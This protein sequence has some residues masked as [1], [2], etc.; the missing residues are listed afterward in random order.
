MMLH[1]SMDKSS[2]KCKSA[3]ALICCL[4][5]QKN[6]NFIES[7]NLKIQMVIQPSQQ[8]RM[9]RQFCGTYVRKEMV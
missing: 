9:L 7:Y 4:S 8:W 3:T 2:E 1:K 6:Y 5:L